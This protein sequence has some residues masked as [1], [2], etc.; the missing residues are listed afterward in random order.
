MKLNIELNT[1]SI[2]EAINALRM[3]QSQLQ[4]EMLNEFLKTA[5]EWV[6]ERANGYLALSTVGDFV[7]W[8][9]RN[10]WKIGEPKNGKIQMTNTADKAVYI[11]FG[12][13]I[14]GSQNKHKNAS[15]TGYKYNVPSRYK[16][17]DD[18]WMFQT[19]E[20]LDDLDL[21]NGSYE[22]L[23]DSDGTVTIITKGAEG[24][25]YAY[26]A[27]VDFREYGAKEI[28]RDIKVRYWG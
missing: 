2:D 1:K 28:W 19:M 25:M 21:P 3:A 20:G 12:V 27:I 22:E 10:G 26:N 9:I 23:L 17:A 16:G 5:C 18:S 24:V 6:R 14:V 7:K 4:G 8:D 13:G 15:A 11:E